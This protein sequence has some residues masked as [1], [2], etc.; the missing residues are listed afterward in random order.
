MQRM[1]VYSYSGFVRCLSF[2]RVAEHL[3]KSPIGQNKHVCNVQ[4]RPQL[5]DPDTPIGPNASRMERFDRIRRADW[6]KDTC[7]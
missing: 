7:R 2:T 1:R 6:S 3:S 4:T 5:T